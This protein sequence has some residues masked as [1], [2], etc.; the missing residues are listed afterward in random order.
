M[1][2]KREINLEEFEFWSG[3]VYVRDYVVNLGLMDDLERII[4]EEYPEGIDETE[5]NDLFW[6]EGDT[7]AQWL[8]YKNEEELKEASEGDEEEEE[9][10][11]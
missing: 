11:Y 4:D 2:V 3:A 1:I 5:L 10:D 8:G 7:I 6:H 9:E